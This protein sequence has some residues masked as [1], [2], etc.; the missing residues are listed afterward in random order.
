MFSNELTGELTETYAVQFGLAQRLR[1]HKEIVPERVEEFAESRISSVTL[2]NFWDLQSSVY[3]ELGMGRFPNQSPR[4][5]AVMVLLGLLLCL[6]FGVST[7]H[8]PR[9]SYPYYDTQKP[10]PPW[11]EPI[12]L[13]G[14]D[15]RGAEH[16]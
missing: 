2:Q 13:E 12:P 15:D 7:Y 10:V 8:A 16:K 9:A 6:W 5:A 3:V 1:D 14:N 4:L 11:S